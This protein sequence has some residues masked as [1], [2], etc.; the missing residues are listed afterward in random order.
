MSDEL[1]ELDLTAVAKLIRSRRVSAVEVT[2]ACLNRIR[3]WQP[4]INAF[5]AVEE[6][7]AL[8][9]A[10]ACDEVLR[11]GRA[12]GPLHGVPMAH[13][14]MFYRKDEVSSA[15][16][17]IR[18][19]WVATRDATVLRKLDAAGAVTL[20]RLNMSEFAAHPLGENDHFGDCLTPWRP[21]HVA[22]GS[23]SGSGAAVAARLI[24]GA[25][26]SDTGGSIRVPAALNGV[27]GLMPTYGR[28]SRYGVLGRSW[29]LDHVGPFARSAA[30]CVAIFSVIE[31]SDPLDGSSVAAPSRFRRRPSGRLAGL[32]LGI[33]LLPRDV[34][35][36]AAVAGA[37]EDARRIFEDLGAR[38]VSVSL[39][40]LSEMFRLCEIIVRSEAATMHG[41]WMRARPHDYS[42]YMRARIEGG[43][44]IPATWYIE[45]L[46]HRGRAL[47]NFRQTVFGNCDVLYL[48]TVP[49]TAPH[50]SR[51][52][53][54]DPG[55]LATLGGLAAFTRPFNFLG[56]P[57]LTTPC[58]FNEQGLPLAFQLVGQP[59]AE[60]LLLHIANRYQHVTDWRRRTPARIG[61][62][63]A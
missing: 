49:I 62:G 31:G 24:Y 36:D 1:C 34:K 8:R 59:F 51:S 35:I 41:A 16:S 20:G 37:L 32:R 40:D 56:L 42:P 14:D 38:T 30:D 44:F 45:A 28:V 11:Q 29:S 46:A 9:R 52:P 12:V 23:S 50:S 47:A 57:S 48:P 60:D 25:L 21:G 17:A 18:R 10:K 53:D 63:D 4:R 61:W 6:E 58:G 5:I 26:G 7:A 13:K 2:E 15:G 22:G 55:V 33:P 19:T 27:C 39:P 3:E 43:F 54:T